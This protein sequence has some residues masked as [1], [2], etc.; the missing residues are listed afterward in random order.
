MLTRNRIAV[1]VDGANFYATQK[2]LGFNI[3]W[4][5]MLDEIKKRGSL[6]R[7]YYYSATLPGEQSKVIPLLDYLVYNGYCVVTKEAKRYRSR[8]GEDKIK[9]NMDIELVCHM[10]EL[11]Y[12]GMVDSMLL[13]S[14]DGDFAECVRVCQRRGVRVAVMSTIQSASPMCADELRRQADEFVDLADWKDKVRG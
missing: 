10:I 4:S 9:G 13:M 5:K 14:G 12:S 8:V 6:L 7:A 1:F 3:D 11:A 2:L